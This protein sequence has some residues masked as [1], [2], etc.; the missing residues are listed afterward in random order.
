MCMVLVTIRVE[1]ISQVALGFEAPGVHGLPRAL[2]GGHIGGC[3][4]CF[5][6]ECQGEPPLWATLCFAISKPL[7]QLH[8]DI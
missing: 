7:L 5:V 8:L 3:L 1:V 2:S 6:F 4:S